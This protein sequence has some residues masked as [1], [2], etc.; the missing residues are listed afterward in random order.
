MGGAFSKSCTA[1]SLVNSRGLFVDTPLALNVFSTKCRR[2]TGDK[3]V[4]STMK[5]PKKIQT[6]F[7]ISFLVL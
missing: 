5:A 6:Y 2:E 4:W 3:S 1:F 7:N